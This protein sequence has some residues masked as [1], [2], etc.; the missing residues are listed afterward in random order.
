MHFTC[1]SRTLASL[2]SHAHSVILCRFPCNFFGHFHKRCDSIAYS[3]GH[4]QSSSGP[5]C[6]PFAD[7]VILFCANVGDKSFSLC[8]LFPLLFHFS[9]LVRLAIDLIRVSLTAFHAF[10]SAS[11]TRSLI[12]FLAYTHTHARTHSRTHSLSHNSIKTENQLKICYLAHPFHVSMHFMRLILGIFRSFLL[13]LLFFNRWFL[14]VSFARQSI[15]STVA[16][17][18]LQY[19][20]FFLRPNAPHTTHN[21]TI[22]ICT[23]KM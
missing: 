7:C 19:I 6:I 22:S 8:Q 12:R 20:H 13:L 11:L 4:T 3:D 18:K 9:P 14:S 2:L 5:S 17:S 23:V 1:T 10:H 21:N 15:S 16:T